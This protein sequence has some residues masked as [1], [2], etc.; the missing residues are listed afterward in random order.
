MCLDLKS[1]HIAGITAYAADKHLYL[2]IIKGM[3]DKYPG[4]S[5]GGGIGLF[6][7]NI[8]P[9]RD[10]FL[11]DIDFTCSHLIKGFSEKEGATSGTEFTHEGKVKGIKME[12][13]IDENQ[14]IPTRLVE[15][16]GITY[17]V[18]HYFWTIARKMDYAAKGNEKQINDCHK[19]LSGSIGFINV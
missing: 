14:L 9:P 18:V 7:Q 16:E 1:D 17:R 8:V 4:L 5:V 10:P 15:F 13:C 3:Q 2:S 6:L 12:L 11:G 19:L